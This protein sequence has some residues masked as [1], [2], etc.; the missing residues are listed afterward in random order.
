MFLPLTLPSVPPPPLPPVLMRCARG[1]KSGRLLLNSAGTR[2]VAQ[3]VR[4]IALARDVSLVANSH[5]G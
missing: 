3:C 1:G 2:E 4:A 5:I